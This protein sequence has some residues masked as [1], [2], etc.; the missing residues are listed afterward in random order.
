MAVR[1]GGAFACRIIALCWILAGAFPWMAAE[2]AVA[3]YVPGSFC[4]GCPRFVP[5]LGMPLPSLRISVFN[6]LRTEISSKS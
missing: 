3:K 5:H 6:G 1:S 4:Q 2:F